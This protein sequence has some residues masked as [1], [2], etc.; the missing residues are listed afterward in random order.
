MGVFLKNSR[1]FYI[2]F[3]F[4]FIM[5]LLSL[6]N[7]SYAA[8]VDMKD[9]LLDK[10]GLIEVLSLQESQD[11]GSSYENASYGIVLSEYFDEYYDVSCDWDMDAPESD[12]VSVYG[13]TVGLSR[14]EVETIF[15]QDNT[16]LF[17][18]DEN[19]LNIGYFK[20]NNELFSVSIQWENDKV[21]GWIFSNFVEFGYVAEYIIDAQEKY[22]SV[23]DSKWKR[24]MIEY[25]YDIEDVQRTGIPVELYLAYVN[26]D[27]I[28]ELYIHTD[29]TATGDRM[30][31]WTPDG[32]K[33]Q[34]IWTGC[35]SYIEG[36][37]LFAELD[38]GHM[39]LYTD[40]VYSIDS[41]DIKTIASGERIEVD[42]V[43]TGQ[44]EQF[45][46]KWN[47]A[48]VS[49]AEYESNLKSVYD[50]SKAINFKDEK[51]LEFQEVIEKIV[52]AGE[53][54]NSHPDAEEEKEDN[55]E[56]LFSLE[57]VS[58][59]ESDDFDKGKI[60]IDYDEKDFFTNA[61][62][63]NHHLAC[64]AASLSTL[65]YSVD[66]AHLENT[67]DKLKYE[68]P[69]YFPDD[70]AGDGSSGQGLYSPFYLAYKYIDSK[71]TYIITVVIRGTYHE[72]WV[73]N[74]EIGKN[75]ESHE[76]FQTA[77]NHLYDELKNYIKGKNL[78]SKNVKI[79][80]TGHSRGAA[81]ANL[82]G[83]KIDD[84]SIEGV[85]VDASNVFVYTFAT[86]NTTSNG[87]RNDEKYNNIYNIVNPE[88]FV[89]KVVPSKWHFGR[90][91]ISYVL[92]SR[93]TDNKG[94]SGYVNYKLYLKSVN[95]KFG[96]YTGGAEYTPYIRGI[97]PVSEY[98]TLVTTR[99]D[100]IEKYYNTRL[101]DYNHMFSSV[102][103]I[104]VGTLHDLYSLTL[105]GICSKNSKLIALA[106]TEIIAASLYKYGLVGKATID[107]F[108]VHYAAGV[109]PGLEPTFLHAHTS[110]T[111]LAQMNTIAI[112]QL[113]TPRKMI[114]GIVNCPVD[115]TIK[116][117]NGS[118]VGEIKDN[119][120]NENIEDGIVM[121]VDGDSKSFS[122][123][124]D[125]GY[126][127][128]LTGND[129]GTMD[130]SLC[131]VDAD[132][133]EIERTYYED[134]PI[135]TNKIYTQDI[136]SG[137]VP[138]DI[139]LVNS[140]NDV[141]E[142]TDNMDQEA[143]GQLT[144]EVTVEGVGSADSLYGLTPGDYVTLTA[145]TD[146]NNSFL[147]WF[148]ENGE[149]VSIDEEYSFSI[150]KSMKFTAKFTDVIVDVSSITFD[151]EKV[152]MKK[153][154]TAYNIPQVMPENATST[155]LVFE[156]SNVNAVEVD[157]YGLLTAIGEGESTITAK[158][159]D[160][161]AEASFIVVVSGE[162]GSSSGNGESGGGGD[163]KTSPLLIAG[164]ISLIVIILIS[165]GIIIFQARK[166]KYFTDQTLYG[167]SAEEEPKE[168]EPQK[169]KIGVVIGVFGSCEGQQFVLRPGQK[170]SVGKSSE[171]NFQI[172]NKVISRQHC[173][174]R[175]LSEDVFEVTDHS[176]NGTFYNNVRLEK[177]KPLNI[178]KDAILALG[179]ANNIIQVQVQEREI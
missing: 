75:S 38:G 124:Q 26:D 145:V 15:S 51:A 14:E 177:D 62:K 142:P 66:K 35:G 30:C 21:A 179:D 68:K 23:H 78:L 58:D 96:E 108:L 42:G 92:P 86:P 2:L 178:P 6:K 176:T 31:T 130:Y 27:E 123:P 147:G 169:E 59:Y 155:F 156:S 133:G 157:G 83:A 9:Y 65:I 28:P 90:Y 132:T 167:E 54:G 101:I 116:D 150:K 67:F 81:V 56:E 53:N 80:I 137:D 174:I 40:K 7:I 136:K 36:A 129:N 71:D 47:D 41:D 98:I 73:N 88:D 117:E 114:W 34:F 152:T 33:E 131:Y 138:K 119:Q 25:I 120:I 109:A 74:F 82:L 128:E 10:Q 159:A 95:D 3:G 170:C 79:L 165:I 140:N 39:G 118:I 84:E 166:E 148:D 161:K 175:M 44:F 143:F 91:G 158:S 144:V 125:E 50:R 93:S 77:C 121:Y 102:A 104:A 32:I 48:E 49:E 55:Q 12:H 111:Y 87:H 154:E 76:G 113:V 60:K 163:K 63:Y 72:E 134:V 1:K 105:G 17:S 24:D 20:L 64:Y 164:V 172:K 173:T 146:Q 94:G 127:V 171:C 46:Y 37:N 57:Y 97:Y 18:T 153:G 5:V 61:A 16:Y 13:I 103:L 100:S 89:T 69:K 11:I 122:L 115:V 162:E 141:V 139:D 106:T 149:L 4:F 168:D 29:E 43:Q 52:A 70:T 22:G 160:G 135:E 85:D 151:K 126:T 112:E 19:G 99:V 45:V 110:E 8:A 107:Y